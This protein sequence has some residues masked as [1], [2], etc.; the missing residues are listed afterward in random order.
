MSAKKRELPEQHE[1]PETKKQRKNS[2]TEDYYP[3]NVELR[4]EFLTLPFSNRES[5]LKRFYSGLLR[6]FNAKKIGAGDCSN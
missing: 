1:S 3:H 4:S 2:E 6:C 5:I